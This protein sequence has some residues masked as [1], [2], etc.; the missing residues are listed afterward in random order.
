MQFA[1]LVKSKSLKERPV[2]GASAAFT[3]P[4]VPFDEEVYS[5]GTEVNFD[6]FPTR[7]L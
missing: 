5:N 7:S 6:Q 4:E 1:C 3:S 2:E